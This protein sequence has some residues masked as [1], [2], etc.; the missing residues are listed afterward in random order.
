MI[1]GCCDAGSVRAMAH[2]PVLICLPTLR[3]AWFRFVQRMDLLRLPGRFFLGFLQHMGQLAA[4]LGELAI[5]FRSRVW[6]LK[7]VAH[8]IVS[9][10]Y[11][12]QTVVIVTGAFTGAVFTFQMYG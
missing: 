4:L 11:G 6:R 12:S 10:G 5:A 7:L 9:I 2:L 8:Q 3:S 1:C